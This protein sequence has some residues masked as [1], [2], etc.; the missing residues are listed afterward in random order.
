MLGQGDN[1]ANDPKSMEVCE[2]CG[3]FLIVGDAQSRVD[4]HYTGKQHL[5]FAK[6][7]ATLDE[8]EVLP[9]FPAGV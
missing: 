6:I 4:E 3:C 2:T 8:V 1:P 7:K 5:G 9:I